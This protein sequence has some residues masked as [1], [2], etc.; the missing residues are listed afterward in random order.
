M[1]QDT[2]NKKITVT[3]LLAML[4]AVMLILWSGCQ[5]SPSSPPSDI[6]SEPPPS[7]VPAIPNESIVTAKII[8]IKKLPDSD[9]CELIIDI[10]KSES[11]PGLAN[12]FEQRIGEKIAVRTIE[13][14]TKLKKDQIITAHVSLVGDERN[15]YISASNIQ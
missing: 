9:F 12:I 14:V 1:I 5:F 7:R 11:V 13:D 3:F 10:Q 15:H 8:D 4:P 2:H 6:P